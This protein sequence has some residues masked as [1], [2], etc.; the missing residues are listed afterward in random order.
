MATKDI[1]FMSFLKGKLGEKRI[2]IVLISILAALTIYDLTNLVGRE[3]LM[4]F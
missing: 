4:G 2:F 1:H 3:K